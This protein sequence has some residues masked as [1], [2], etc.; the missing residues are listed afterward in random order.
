MRVPDLSIL[1]AAPAAPTFAAAAEH[2]RASRI[3]A[4][5]GTRV[6]HRVALQRAMPLLGDLPLGEIT[7]EHGI[8]LVTSLSDA[9]ARRGTIRKT[10]MYARAVLDEADIEPNP[11]RDKRV[12]LPHE[13]DDEIV[14]PEAEHVKPSTARSRRCIACRSSGSTEAARASPPSTSCSSA[15]TTS[16]ARASGSA[17]R[18]AR[19][20]AASG[21]TCLPSSPRRSRPRSLRARIAT[22]PHG[23]PCERSRRAPYLDRQDLKG[24]RRPAVLAARPPAPAHQRP[25]SARPVVRRDRRV[26]RTPQVLDLR[27]RLHAR[28]RRRTRDRPAHAPRRMKARPIAP[29]PRIALTREEAAASLGMS[30]RAFEQRVQP[31]LRLIRRGRLRLVPL[32]ELERWRTTQ[33]NG[34]SRTSRT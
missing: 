3:D 4:T 29:V 32:R 27:R 2:W 15:T 25:A 8:R 31:D 17:R 10:L 9:G 23:Y 28:P 16:R 1:A 18:S 30:L 26:R 20:D 6:V 24:A 13:E 33:P 19:R 21:S 5:D 22:R 7:T 34:R 11:L 12:R 14:P